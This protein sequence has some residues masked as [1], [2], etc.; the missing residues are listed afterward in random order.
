MSRQE[1]LILK[2]LREGVHKAEAASSEGGRAR[3]GGRS[4]ALLHI[5]RVKRRAR[6]KVSCFWSPEWIPKVLC[7]DTASAASD[8]EGRRGEEDAPPPPLEGAGARGPG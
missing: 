7:K 3:T 2:L 1:C 5:S 4:A 8:G 6:G